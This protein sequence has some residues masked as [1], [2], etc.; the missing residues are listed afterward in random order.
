TRL[1]S[2]AWRS[3]GFVC[4]RT[5]P[6]GTAAPPAPFRGQLNDPATFG[7]CGF[8]ILDFGLGRENAGG[9]AVP[10]LLPFQSKIQNPQ[11]KIPL[12][13]VREQPGAVGFEDLDVLDG[14]PAF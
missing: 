3:E 12:A 5:T 14:E 4:E 1:F 9:N 7:D 11:S 8:L 2:I 13:S 6:P 10:S